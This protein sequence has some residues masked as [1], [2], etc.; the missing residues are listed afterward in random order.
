MLAIIEGLAVF[1]DAN[2]SK[3]WILKIVLNIDLHIIY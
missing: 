1:A 2:S 3:L